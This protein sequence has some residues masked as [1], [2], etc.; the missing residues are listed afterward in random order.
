MARTR[1]QARKDQAAAPN[2]TQV[3]QAEQPAQDA[4]APEAAPVAQD[5]QA[6]PRTAASLFERAVQALEI[7][8]EESD[9][10]LPVDEALA[11]LKRDTWDA[12]A[13]DDLPPAVAVAVFDCAVKQG[14]ATAR[15]LLHRALGLPGADEVGEAVLQA[16]ADV[17]PDDLLVKLLAW[18]LR[19]YSGTANAASNMVAWASHVLTLQTIA[20]HLAAEEGGQ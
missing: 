5:A 11:A 14:G 1:N 3:A 8:V 10:S 6:T 13:C 20:L 16:I 12:N 7:D 15:R 9:I 4:Q 17:D 19:R 18:R 2:P